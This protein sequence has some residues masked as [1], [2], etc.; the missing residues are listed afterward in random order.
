MRWRSIVIAALATALM[1]FSVPDLIRELREGHRLDAAGRVVAG[2]ITRHYQLSS[3]KGCRGKI[4]VT[5][6][7]GQTRY[8]VSAGWCG[9]NLVGRQV[10]VRYLPSE[11]DISEVLSPALGIKR[12]RRGL[13]ALA[14][15]ILIGAAI[16]GSAYSE[17]RKGR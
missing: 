10:D 5:Y 9:E 6:E 4:E 17:W 7:A 15:M 12:E 13:G 11:P 8:L 3:G 16:W 14:V 1:F 2:T